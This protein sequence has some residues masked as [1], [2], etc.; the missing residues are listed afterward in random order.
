MPIIGDSVTGFNDFEKTLT[1]INKLKNEKK[2]VASFGKKGTTTVEIRKAK[3]KDKVRE[4][5]SSPGTQREKVESAIED[6]FTKNSQHLLEAY[7]K[8]KD[9][10]QGTLKV[11]DSMGTHHE[12]SLSTIALRVLR[13]DPVNA[14]LVASCSDGTQIKA[15]SFRFSQ[16]VTAEKFQNVTKKYSPD[17]V[18][19]IL[20]FQYDTPKNTYTLNHLVEAAALAHELELYP[21]SMTLTER[22]VRYI[23]ETNWDTKLLNIVLQSDTSLDNLKKCAEKGDAVAMYKLA[24]TIG[25]ETKEGEQWLKKA[26]TKGFVLALYDLGKLYEDPRMHYELPLYTEDRHKAVE[27]YN[28]AAAKGLPEA[29]Y[30]LYLRYRTRDLGKEM[31]YRAAIG[32]GS[33]SSIFAGTITG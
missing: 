31:L 4:W 6:H 23:R 21:L 18:N 17:A 27:P 19:I 7:K 10:L 24:K 29:D 2:I 26:A 3:F 22:G 12:V 33:S 1:E 13:N 30:R 8:N 16:N 15:H 20:D 14:D 28:R 11:P 25:L 5:F 32:G 9:L